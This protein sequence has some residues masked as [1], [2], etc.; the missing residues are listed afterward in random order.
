MQHLCR[1][2][3][4]RITAFALV[5]SLTPLWDD[6]PS[7][8][9]NGLSR[10]RREVLVTSAIEA[11]PLY[12]QKSAA[13]SLWPLLTALAVTVLFI[14][15]IFTPWALTWGSV[16]VLLTL[17]GWFWPTRPRATTGLFRKRAT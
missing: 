11:R 7:G 9:L 17:T 5:A 14:G 10:D 4:S 12:R 6:E 8:V 1:F 15:S 3:R 16:P 13:P 2:T